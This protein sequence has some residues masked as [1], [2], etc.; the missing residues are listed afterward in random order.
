MYY[1]QLKIKIN[2]K[3]ISKESY[4]KYVH[5]SGSLDVLGKEYDTKDKLR[6]LERSIDIEV[7]KLKVAMSKDSYLSPD[8][9]KEDL[10]NRIDDLRDKDKIYNQL[11][12][13]IVQLPI[14]E[15]QIKNKSDEFDTIRSK[16]DN[17]ENNIKACNYSKNKYENVV[18]TYERSE[19]KLKILNKE[20]NEIK[21]KATQII[22]D[23]ENLTVKLT[24]NDILKEKLENITD[25]LKLLKDIREL[26]SKDGIQKDLR[27]RSK[28]LIQKK[29]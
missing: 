17:I 18:F 9:R 10:K 28:P 6:E 19:E 11:K 26:F 12:G 2:Y 23:I 22:S 29:Y 5:A 7:E 27:N 15:S 16:V 24:Q 20:I 25:Y 14:L 13:E 4:D 1:Y 8:I 21:G 3:K